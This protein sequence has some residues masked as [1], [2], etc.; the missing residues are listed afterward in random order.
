MLYLVRMDVKIP[1][2]LPADVAAE[3]K[4]R[5]KAYSQQLQHE[6]RWPHIWRVVGEYANY[7]V[8]DVAS[9]DELHELLQGLPLFPY[10]DIQVTP[11]A[12]HPSAIA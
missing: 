11:L 4:A 3:I 5:E 1:H 2:D 9:N 6:G 12:R 10:M 7:S 8:F